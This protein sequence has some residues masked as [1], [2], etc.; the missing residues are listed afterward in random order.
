MQPHN[1]LKS[2]KDFADSIRYSGDCIEGIRPVDYRAEESYGL[3]KNHFY[4]NE[5]LI[6]ESVTPTLYQAIS[7]V[8]KR[9]SIQSESVSAFVYAS[10]EINAHCLL[11]SS[12]E[13]ILRFSSGLIELLSE[14]E[15]E[16]IV[17]HELGHFLFEHVGDSRSNSEVDI[18][19]VI[20]L[21]AQEISADRIG[22]VGCESLDIAIKA[23]LK[24]V[25][26]L[27]DQY[28]RFDISKFVSQLQEIAGEDTLSV[29]FSHPSMLVRC[30]ALLWF[31]MS[32]VYLDVNDYNSNDLKTLDERVKV[33]MDRYVDSSS[34]KLIEFAKFETAMWM[35]AYSIIQKDKFTKDDQSKFE[36]AFGKKSLISLIQLVS[37]LDKRESDDFIFSQLT[38]ARKNLEGMIPATF[39]K[40]I[41]KLQWS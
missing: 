37:E 7:R 15:L 1:G 22:L 11:S 34:R 14:N 39:N 21:R 31:S 9:L 25:S 32:H 27:S 26:G 10:S 20:Q 29:E 4:A 13:C 30:R 12:S 16:F 17:A 40:E 18:E 35:A 24:T 5:L 2:A 33:D 23:I 36:T 38:T 8:L 6:S 28:L 41:S 3:M 19:G